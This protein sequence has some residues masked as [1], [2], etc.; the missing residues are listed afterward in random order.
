MTYGNELILYNFMMAQNFDSRLNCSFPS[1]KK[2]G[3]I[4]HESVLDVP[5][6]WWP[7]TIQIITNCVRAAMHHCHPVPPRAV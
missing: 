7:A 2:T 5:V 4:V 3:I 1:L 6:T